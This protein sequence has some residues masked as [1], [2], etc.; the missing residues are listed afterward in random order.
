MAEKKKRRR[1][2]YKKVVLSPL[3]QR[4]ITIVAG[5]RLFSALGIAVVLVSLARAITEPTSARWHLI[6]LAALL[7][8]VSAFV[9]IWYGGYAARKEERRIR[10]RL[11]GTVFHASSLPKAS[12]GGYDS[13]KLIAM[14]TDNAERVT[15]YRQVYFG[16][17]IAAMTIPFLTSIYVT[18]AIDLLI[19]LVLLVMCP[20]IPVLIAGFMRLFRKTSAHSRKARGKLAGEYLDA[21]RNLVTI[22]LFGAGPRIEE[23]LREQGER[24]RGAIMKLL[25]GNQI[26]IIVM[27]GLFSLLLI[28]LT[29]ALAIARV[30]AGAV[31]VGEAL[32]VVFLAVLLIEPLV[33]VAGFFYI[34]MGGM[35]SERAIGAYLTSATAS[36]ES[37]VAAQDYPRRSEERANGS[38]DLRKAQEIYSRVHDD[39]DEGIEVSNLSYNYGRGEVL[40]DI[41]FEVPR[42]SKVAIVGRSGA[43]KSTLLSLLRGSLPLQSGS[44]RIGGHDLNSMGVEEIRS[45]TASVSQSTWLFTGTIADNLRLA[46]PDASEEEMWEALRLAHVTE[47]IERMPSGLSTDVGEQGALISG[48]QAQR[49]S[50]ARAFLSGRR[51]LLL[52]EPTSQ[53]DIGSEQKIIEAIA[54]LG[55]EWTLLMVTHRTSLLAVADRVW[56]MSE[57][58]L[59]QMEVAR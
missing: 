28:C 20:L 51:I 21:I 37:S 47:D 3:G 50:L 45:L 43:G 13:G 34:G 11:L 24:N 25:A 58:H 36:G 7:A 9:E 6:V 16:A 48:G 12:E 31:N 5:A 38:S 32:A 56:D 27:D 42:G 57:G 15:E 59:E 14:M 46:K 40:H 1:P 23:H 41:T 39:A 19:G 33:Q 26:V 18:V 54:G 4:D 29:A 49:I 44:I 55:R 17:T 22:R 8:G 30:H 2:S 53:V 35:A 10:H 52:D